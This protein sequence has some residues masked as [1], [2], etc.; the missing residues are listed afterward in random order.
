MDHCQQAHD[1][2]EKQ[3]QGCV[4][5]VIIPTNLVCVLFGPPIPIS[6]FSFIVFYTCNNKVS[7]SCLQCTDE[8]QLGQNCAT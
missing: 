4:V 8:A 2:R 7:V 1:N 3:V 5:D 6:S